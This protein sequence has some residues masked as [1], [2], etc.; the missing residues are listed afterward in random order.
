MSDE[1]V[2]LPSILSGM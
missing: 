2:I 1:K